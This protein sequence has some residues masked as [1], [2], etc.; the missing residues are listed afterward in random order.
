MSKARN[1]TTPQREHHHLLETQKH[2]K[3]PMRMLNIRHIQLK[4]LLAICL[5][6][7]PVVVGAFAVIST[8]SRYDGRRVQCKDSPAKT[9][10]QATVAPSE[11][12]LKP[13]KEEKFTKEAQELMATLDAKKVSD[14]LIVAQV[15]PA[16]R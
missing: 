16:V 4:R 9:Q 2:V 3:R 14:L 13:K 8:S 7:L 1:D 15:A 6:Y 12:Y 10:L 5:L 11:E